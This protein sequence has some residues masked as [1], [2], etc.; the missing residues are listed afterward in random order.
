[1]GIFEGRSMHAQRRTIVS[2]ANFSCIGLKQL[3]PHLGGL[4]NVW[5]SSLTI[6]ALSHKAHLN[7]GVS[8]KKGCIG[9][10]YSM[11]LESPPP[12]HLPDKQ[13]NL[14]VSFGGPL[15]LCICN[16]EGVSVCTMCKTPMSKT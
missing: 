15:R 14:I 7:K 4:M 1:M 12:E 10:S 13:V 2:W 3:V 11:G 5:T 8:D 16:S 9:K 6:C